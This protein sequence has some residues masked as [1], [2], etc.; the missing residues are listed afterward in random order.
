MVENAFGSWNRAIEAADLTRRIPGG[1]YRQNLISDDELLA[2]I[3]R[4]TSQL[5]KPPSGREMNALGRY[6]VKPY[7]TNHWCRLK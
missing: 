4:L 5:G 1:Q 3:G 7:R 6:S 2:E